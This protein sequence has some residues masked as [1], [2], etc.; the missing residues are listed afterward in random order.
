MVFQVCL[1]FYVFIRGKL[2]AQVLGGSEPALSVSLWLEPL[3]GVLGSL[4]T[5]GLLDSGG[6]GSKYAGGTSSNTATLLPAA[7]ATMQ[8]FSSVLPLLH[9]WVFRGSKMGRD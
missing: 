4:T 1:S 3:M 8:I 9:Q 6:K 7:A 2:H 5:H